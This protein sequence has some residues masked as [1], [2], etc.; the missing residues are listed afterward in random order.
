M[1]YPNSECKVRKEVPAFDAIK[2]Q[3]PT[4]TPDGKEN[5]CIATHLQQ[6]TQKA[7]RLAL[8]QQGTHTANLKQNQRQRARQSQ[9]EENRIYFYEDEKVK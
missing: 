7:E 8:A 3:I 4:K 9:T 2:F 6:H 5:T 1:D